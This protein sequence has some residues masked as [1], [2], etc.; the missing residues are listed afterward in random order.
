MLVFVKTMH[1]GNDRNLLV[2]QCKLFDFV[3]DRFDVD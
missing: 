3:F 2:G 1:I